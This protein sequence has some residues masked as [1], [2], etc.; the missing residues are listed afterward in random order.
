MSIGRADPVMPEA[1]SE[2]RNATYAAMFAV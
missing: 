2:Q 1:S